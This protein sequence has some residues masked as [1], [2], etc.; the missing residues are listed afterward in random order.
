MRGSPAVEAMVKEQ[1]SRLQKRTAL[2]S[3]CRSPRAPQGFPDRDATKGVGAARRGD[4][5]TQ[6]L[7]SDKSPWQGLLRFGHG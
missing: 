4:C 5:R 1:G 3:L 6:H 7:T 2:Q